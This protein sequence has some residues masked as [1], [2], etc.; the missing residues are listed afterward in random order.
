MWK[1]EIKSDGDPPYLALVEEL[2]ADIVEGRLSEGERLPTHRELADGL[3]LAVGTVTRAYKEAE[4]RGLIRGEIGR[5]TFVR[6]PDR[7]PVALPGNARTDHSSV[8]DLSINYPIYGEDPDLA[9]ALRDLARQNDVSRL[10]QYQPHAG[11]PRHRAAGA[12]W[13]KRIGMEVDPDSIL[14]CGGAQHA[15]TV[16]FLTVCNAGDVVLTEE[17]TYPGMKVMANVLGLR[18][19]GVAMDEQGIRPDALASACRQRHAKALYCVPTL[20]NPTTSIASQQRRREIAAVA[21]EF[22]LAIV[23]DEMHRLLV[24]DPPP[25]ITSIAPKRSY[26]IAGTS[27]AVA[28][29]L[30]VAYLVAPEGM[31][32]R[33]S[34]SIYGTNW[35]VAPLPAEIMTR[36][37][38]DGTAEQTVQR[39][40]NEAAA[41]QEIARELLGHVPYR[42]QPYSYHIWLEL[43]ADCRSAEFAIEARRKGVAVTP[44]DSF[45]VGSGS[46]PNAIRVCLGAAETR[47]RLRRGLEILA[48]CLSCCENLGVA[49]V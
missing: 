39:K 48:R 13:L 7:D 21:E 24:D 30:R 9:A 44:A 29:G 6:G 12:R 14:V 35:M 2:N 1:P 4:R 23:E 26:L 11:M 42:S 5:G 33:L 22:G 20:Q 16:A 41:R 47:E 36:W 8:V 43:P 37:I 10:L 28:G 18:L 31:N 15:M 34:Q 27:K 25:T 32:D 38:E 45:M 19:V 49:M 46:P 40:R 17:L 3:G